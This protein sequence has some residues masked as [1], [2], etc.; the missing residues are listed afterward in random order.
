MARDELLVID[1]TYE[2]LKWFLGH[3][4]KFPRSHR[5]GIRQQIEQRLYVVFRGLL[6]A[7][8]SQLE[9]PKTLPRESIAQT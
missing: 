9:L 5:Y 3:L 4:G 8:L 1:R 6:R 2:L 7:E